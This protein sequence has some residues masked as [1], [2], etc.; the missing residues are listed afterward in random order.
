MWKFI[1]L[2]ICDWIE[3]KRKTGELFHTYKEFPEED[4]HINLKIRFNEDFKDEN[5]FLNRYRDKRNN[6]NEKGCL[7]P[8]GNAKEISDWLARQ[9]IPEFAYQPS[10]SKIVE[11][12]GNTK[13]ELIHEFK[14]ARDIRNSIKLSYM[15]NNYGNKYFLQNK[16]IYEEVRRGVEIPLELI[17]DIIIT[18]REFC[19]CWDQI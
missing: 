6:E 3:D 17:R 2:N 13:Y 5:L 16:T 8:K 18:I 14:D 9:I 1:A 11:D 4:G 19:R 15:V 10:T 7:I 12:Y